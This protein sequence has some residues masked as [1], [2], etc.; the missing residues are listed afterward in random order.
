MLHGMDTGNSDSTLP[1]LQRKLDGFLYWCDTNYMSISASKSKW[2]IFGQPPACLGG[3]IVGHDA[4]ER[5]AAYKFVGVWFSS[6]TRDIFSKHYIEK[7][8]KACRVACASF[9][10]EDFIGTLAPTEGKC[11]YMARVDPILTFAAE[12]VLDVDDGSVAKLTD[13]QHL[14]IRRLLQV[15]QRS[16]VAALFTETGL[17]PLRFRRV[18][19]AIGYLVYLEG[20]PVGHYAYGA[21]QESKSLLR[22]GFSCWIA[23]LNW[24]ISHLPG[25]LASG[26]DVATMD[27]PQLL[28]LQKA[29]VRHCDA[30]LTD[31]LMGST[32]CYLLKGRLELGADGGPLK[33]VRKLRQ[34]LVLPVIPAH[35]RAFTSILFSTHGL[36]VERLRWR[37]RYRDPVPREWCLCRFCRANVED[38]VH[39]LLECEGDISHPLGPLRDALRMEVDVLVPDFAWHSDSLTLLLRLLH[40]SQLPVPVAKY[41]YDV[42]AVFYSVPMYVPAPYLYSPLLHSQA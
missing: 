20:L 36:A 39:A 10:L 4:I 3:L 18:I 16:V 11:L 22:N 34:Y 1:G 6:T 33:V 30:H 38:E 40:D 28:S 23:D 25:G 15:G 24:V 14:Y 21:L 7:S 17:L 26:T 31:A 2:M 37:E 12:I 41:V 29:I 13:V 5:V 8:S 27:I 19:L 35:R 32:K 42:L 9:A